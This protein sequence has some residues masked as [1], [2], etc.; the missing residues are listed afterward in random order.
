MGESNSRPI[1]TSMTKSE[2]AEYVASCRKS[3][4]VNPLTDRR[5]DNYDDILLACE[6]VY[7]SGIIFP[8]FE[9]RKDINVIIPLEDLARRLFDYFQTTVKT[10]YD[11]TKFDEF[12]EKA[13]DTFL[14]LINSSRSIKGYAPLN[15]GSAQK[16]INMVFKYL[17]CYKDYATYQDCFEHCHMPIDSKI[18]C[19]LKKNYSIPNINCCLYTKFCGG[20]TFEGKSWTKF[21]KKIYGNLLKITRTTIAKASKYKGKTLLEIEF[22]IWN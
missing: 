11:E 5:I 18:L 3:V 12:H 13:C 16:M 19:E 20:A 22:E 2:F 14:Q 9:K 8:R 17:A 7:S 21:D 4:R 6:D 15:Y 10:P 1:T